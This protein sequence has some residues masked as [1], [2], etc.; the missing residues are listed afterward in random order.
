MLGGEVELGQSVCTVNAA[1]ALRPEVSPLAVTVW[2]PG[3]AWSGTLSGTE[4]A[5]EGSVMVVPR[6][7]ESKARSTVSESPNPV[8]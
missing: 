2:A 6:G 5:P 7:W 4:K 3:R 8:P 1:E